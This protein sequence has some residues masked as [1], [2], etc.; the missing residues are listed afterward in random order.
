MPNWSNIYYN[1][2]YVWVGLN[3]PSYALD[4][5]GWIQTNL[6][7]RVWGQI[8]SASD[9]INRNNA[10]GNIHNHGNKAV[11]DGITSGQVANR[12]T[13]YGRGN[14]ATF[15][16]LTASALTPYYLASNPSGYI[17]NETD[18]QVWSLVN[19][20]RCYATGSTS[21]VVC[22]QDAPTGT[23]AGNTTEI[24]FNETGAFWA[25]ANFVWNVKDMRL[26]IW[27]GTPEYTVDVNGAIKSMDLISSLNN[28]GLTMSV[29]FTYSGSNYCI[30][31]ENGLI[32][33]FGNLTLNIWKGTIECTKTSGIWIDW[34]LSP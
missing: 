30:R 20:K 23:P 14:H 27:T 15:W 12:N 6:G 9:I 13:A 29:P 34:K 5:S 32:V 7:I 28:T 16:Y 11:L 24:Q 33:W 26:W 25:D 21:A 22:D 18:P 8:I 17:T 10:Y 19:G 3:N 31:I 4:V 1:L 2:W